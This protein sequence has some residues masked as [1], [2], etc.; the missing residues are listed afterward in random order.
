MIRYDIKA[1]TKEWIYITTINPN[2]V[3]ND[4]S[5][6]SNTN[7]GLWQLNLNLAL[8]FWDTT[9]HWGEIIKVILYNERYK[10]GKQ[11][12]MGYVS[13]IS[14]VYDTN[15]GYIKLVCLGVASLLTGIL[16]SWSYNTTATNILNAIISEFNEHYTWNLITVGQIDTYSENINVE[17][18]DGTSCQKAIEQ[19]NEIAN[20]YWFIDGEGKFYFR[21]KGTQ[22]EH[23]MANK[24]EVE[25]MNLNYSIE[26]LVN[27]VFVA[28]K[29]GTVKMYEDNTSQ[30]I[31][32]VKEQYSQQQSI[33]DETTQDEFGNNYITQYS[34]P[35]NASTVVVNSEYDIESIEP[36]DTITIVNSEYEIKGLTI[37]K[38][39]YSPSKVTLTL[40]ENESLWSVISE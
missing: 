8:S 19:V 38:I 34:N 4:I 31:Y 33:V 20:Y 40:E 39:S 27:R 18:K 37:E 6:S 30:S 26:S 16:F 14:R 25:S 10:Q 35:K 17:F 24:Q 36:W 23:I 12:Y 2:V 29:D 3:M 21:K 11:I 5:F 22:T 7:G 32:G 13:Q 1:Y 15:K 9:F 28:R